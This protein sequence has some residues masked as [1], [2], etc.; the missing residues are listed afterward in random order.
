MRDVLERI[1]RRSR[2]VRIEVLMKGVGGDCSVVR[3]K[4]VLE[5]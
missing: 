1:E 3:A 2:G 4:E 5:E